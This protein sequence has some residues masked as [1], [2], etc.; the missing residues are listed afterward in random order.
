M[1][2]ARNA[3]LA[4]VV[5]IGAPCAPA[6]AQDFT[7]SGYGTVG[8]AHS[9]NR[10]ADYLADAKDFRERPVDDGVLSFEKAGGGMAQAA[11]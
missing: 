11:E 6:L 5:T 1:R 3:M 10:D 2:L 4:A 7:L 8:L 9:D